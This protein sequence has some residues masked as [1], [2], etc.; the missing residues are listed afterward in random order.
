MSYRATSKHGTDV[1]IF[2]TV[3]LTVSMYFSLLDYELYKMV[4]NN[5]YS[6]YVLPTFNTVFKMHISY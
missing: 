5:I 4:I 2:V 1:I 3:N 6:L